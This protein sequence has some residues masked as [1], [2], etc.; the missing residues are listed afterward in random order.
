MFQLHPDAPWQDVCVPSE[1]QAV[2]GVPPHVPEAV[3]EQPA[4]AP[5]LVWF[6]PLH[7]PVNVP[8]QL[9]LPSVQPLREMHPRGESPLHEEMVAMH[10]GPEPMAPTPLVPD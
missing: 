3:H 4:C 1:V 10:I 5:Q 8:V 7:E 2:L 6:S 9:E